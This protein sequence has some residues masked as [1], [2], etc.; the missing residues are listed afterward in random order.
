M[1][2]SQKTLE[3]IKP[4]NKVLD[5]GAGSGWFARECLAHEA[6]VTA[7]DLHPPSETSSDIDWHTVDVKYFIERLPKNEKFDVIFSRNLIQ[8]LD[9]VWTEEKLIPTL[10]RHLQPF[11]IIAIQTFY[12]DPNP[13]FESKVPAIF[14]LA[15]LKSMLAPL[16]ALY[17]KEFSEKSLD[18][19]GISRKFFITNIIA[20]FDKKML[21]V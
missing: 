18:M 21:K 7:V 1:T 12:R 8:F 15:D 14:S 13:P 5:L 11:G 3:Y 19:K 9:P 2:F 16:Q 10:L 4:G 17:G 6:Q 20:K